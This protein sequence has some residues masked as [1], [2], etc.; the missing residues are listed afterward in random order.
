MEIRNSWQDMGCGMMHWLGN[1]GK[2]RV[3][4]LSK[5]ISEEPIT[6]QTLTLRNLIFS[7]LDP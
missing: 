1:G 2:K 7:K 5:M 6:Q 4:W 3:T